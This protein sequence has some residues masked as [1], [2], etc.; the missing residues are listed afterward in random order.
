MITL[1]PSILSADFGRLD[2][3]VRE[4]L[5]CDVDWLHV[6]VMDGHFVPNITIGP[7]VVRALQAVK[8]ETGATLDTHLMIENPERYV[9]AFV[10]AGSDIVT[11]HVE[12]ATHLHRVVEQI[13]KAGAKA[14]VALNPATP[15]TAVEEILPYVDLVLLMT[16]N[17]GFGGQSYIPTSTDKIRRMRDIMAAQGSSAYLE[18]DGGVNTKTIRA[19]VEAG[20]DV[21]VAGNAVF[22]GDRSVGENIAALRAALLTEV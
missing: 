17:P 6:D 10:E 22:G 4:A 14:G 15:L 5:A 3:H 1:A 8:K 2:S 11:V 16:V 12:A 13:K 20:A 18:I 19:A 7:L 21:F 9:D